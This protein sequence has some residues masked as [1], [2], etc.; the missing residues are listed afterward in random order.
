M[1]RIEVAKQRNRIFLQKRRDDI[2]AALQFEV[3]RQL[4]QAHREEAA[5]VIQ[6]RFR[7]AVGRRRFQNMLQYKFENL[8]AVRCQSAYR[9][10]LGRRQA[11]AWRRV[12]DTTQFV[13]FSRKRQALILRRLFGRIQRRTQRDFL[14]IAVPLG[15]DPASYT[16]AV[17]SQIDE[18]RRDAKDFVTDIIVE[19]R[20]AY[21]A[22]LCNTYLRRQIR[23][24]LRQELCDTRETP[25]AGDAVRIIDPAHP[26][27]GQTAYIVGIDT[28][29]P[30]KLVAEVKFDLDGANASMP[31]VSAGE[32]SFCRPSTK[33]LYLF[34]HFL[35]S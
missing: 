24:D 3:R 19:S 18:L 33:I 32:K 16:L 35:F 6:R 14:R 13:R 34:A 12:A 7:G 29:I 31:F 4:D 23:T 1:L 28:S 2:A 20:A 5:L 11:A 27:R 22:G 21:R 9:A 26:R 25:Q 15:L 10:V 17:R 30:E 8:A